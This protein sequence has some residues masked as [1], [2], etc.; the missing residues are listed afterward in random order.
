MAEVATIVDT[1]TVSVST[2][3]EQVLDLAKAY[4]QNE[5]VVAKGLYQA[6][7]AGATAGA[8]SMAV[9]E[10]ATILAVAGLAQTTET[11]DLLTTALNAYGLQTDNVALLTERVARLSG[12]F[13]KTVEKGKIEITALAAGI[14][15]VLPVSDALGISMEEVTAAIAALTAGGISSNEAITGLRGTLQAILRP[16]KEAI[17]A[18]EN[19]GIAMGT[20][21]FEGTTF[22]EFL[23]RLNTLYATNK[24]KLTL[25]FPS[26]EGLVPVLSLAGKNAKL[27][28][29][30]LDAIRVSLGADD[31]AFVKITDTINFRVRLAFNRLRIEVQEAF[32]RRLF[33]GLDRAIDRAGGLETIAEK[34]EV[35]ARAAG[36][37]ASDA[38]A[39][40]GD[41][42]G[43]FNEF[44]ERIGGMQTFEGIVERLVAV[45]QSF[46][47]LVK[48]V[49]LDSIESLLVII[50]KLKDFFVALVD[51]IPAVSLFGEEESRISFLRRELEQQRLILAQL[52]QHRV[53]IMRAGIEPPLEMDERFRLLRENIAMMVVE[54]EHLR[55]KLPG[56][57]SEMGR[58][59]DN[60][61]FGFRNSAEAAAEF[62]RSLARVGLAVEQRLPLL[63][64][65]VLQMARANA[66]GIGVLGPV[67]S[68]PRPE[69]ALAIG[70][71]EGP[72]LPPTLLKNAK[73]ILLLRTQMDHFRV[74]VE[75]TRREMK[76]LADELE[77]ASTFSAGFS[78]G[79][80]N[81]QEFNTPF[82]QGMRLA[83]D[84]ISALGS[85][86][87]DFFFQLMQGSISGKEAF[88]AFALS[89]ASDIQ[90]LIARMIALQ[91]I[92]AAIGIF[93]PTPA[94]GKPGGPPDF[95][96]KLA[97]GGIVLGGLDPV[98]AQRGRI[99]RGPTLAVVGDN[100][101]RKEAALPLVEGPGG[102]L[103][104]QSF[105]GGGGLNLTNNWTI[106]TID[107]RGVRD[108]LFG[109]KDFVVS[110]MVEGLQTRPVIRNIF[111]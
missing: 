86:L 88:K 24:D 74:S 47:N 103:G 11:V 94:P 109:E 60:L 48:T 6:I 8:A 91:I 78:E 29:N 90:R 37:L 55:G 22:A 111:N 101:S 62:A 63:Q 19:L 18:A 96:P 34:I 83:Q 59:I 53:S 52:Q 43:S 95:G 30:A 76:R 84:S 93:D 9:L 58:E 14:G 45:V 50:V 21:A 99:F 89:V 97:R 57:I 1:T 72:P 23:V 20:S 110:L 85:S 56:S 10:R 39:S 70:E 80:K 75:A 38:I 4:G 79:I 49:L 15:R 68:Q 28:A 108:M 61:A 81:F 66:L 40:V 65:L 82:R 71:R 12:I 3:T 92:G 77:R 36:L 35:V 27:F 69:G 13:F 41:A 73:S 42:L 106:Q 26:I 46:A 51:A 16:S 100:P 105:G 102:V 7:S 64:T 33:A 5:T 31:T 44:I 107:A 87:E 2:L 104:V 17:D 25:L 67:V 98:S 54:I 32:G